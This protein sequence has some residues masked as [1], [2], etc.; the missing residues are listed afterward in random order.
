MNISDFGK[1][2]DEDVHAKIFLVSGT[3]HPSLDDV[4]LGVHPFHIR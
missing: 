1:T 4:D 2:T 3:V